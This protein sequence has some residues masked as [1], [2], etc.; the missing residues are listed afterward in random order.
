MKFER[1]CGMMVIPVLIQGVHQR[2]LKILSAVHLPY[3]SHVPALCHQL[4]GIIQGSDP[5]IWKI[6]TF[7]GH[8]VKENFSVGKEAFVPFL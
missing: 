4:L 8:S 5:K 1:I 6:E 2:E 7:F 3:Q